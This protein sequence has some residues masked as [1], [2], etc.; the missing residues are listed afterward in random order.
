MASR[1]NKLAVRKKYLPVNVPYT[2]TK[3][4]TH[5]TYLNYCSLQKIIF[6]FNILF[7]L[8]LILLLVLFII[9]LSI[10]LFIHEPEKL[11]R[12]FRAYE[13]VYLANALQLPIGRRANESTPLSVYSANRSLQNIRSLPE[14]KIKIPDVHWKAQIPLRSLTKGRLREKQSK[15][16]IKIFEKEGAKIAEIISVRKRLG[17]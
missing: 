2:P 15:I 12:A 11:L 17:T 3:I 14:V 9:H 7:Q 13:T 1:K 6:S 8:K 10:N 4:D 5:T 16:E